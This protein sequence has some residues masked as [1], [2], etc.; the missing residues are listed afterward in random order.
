MEKGNTN[1]LSD[2]K[3]STIDKLLSKSSCES[4]FLLVFDLESKSIP[5]LIK[6]IK[7]KLNPIFDEDVEQIQS[8]YL[9]NK[10]FV[11]FG[12]YI[13][14]IYI[15]DVAIEGRAVLL[16]WDY[17][18]KAGAKN[19][20]I[21]F[22]VAY[23]TP[24]KSYFEVGNSKQ[25]IQVRLRKPSG[26][27]IEFDNDIGILRNAES[28]KRELTDGFSI[29]IEDID[30]ELYESKTLLDNLV[31]YCDHNGFALND[32]FEP[33][34]FNERFVVVDKLNSRLTD[35]QYSHE[36]SLLR[37]LARKIAIENKGLFRPSSYQVYDSVLDRSYAVDEK[38]NWS[39]I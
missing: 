13:D 21:R 9:D 33:E 35:I 22:T 26:Y 4:Y 16:I 12:G 11:L 18:E 34:Y 37:E 3:S 1:T 5:K 28:F 10:Q 2:L 24:E 17:L 29:F 8:T 25:N 27:D 38:F 30:D 14:P 32:D 23:E 36:E 31:A 15:E 20:E 39:N 19:I 6:R 7:Q